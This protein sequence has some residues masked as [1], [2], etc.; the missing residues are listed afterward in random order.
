MSLTPL[1]LSCFSTK[2]EARSWS[3]PDEYTPMRADSNNALNDD[4]AN[5]EMSTSDNF[6]R[7]SRR[8]HLL[9]GVRLA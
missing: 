6:F 4:T 9:T 1:L 8:L 5:L 2:Y 3:F 7:C